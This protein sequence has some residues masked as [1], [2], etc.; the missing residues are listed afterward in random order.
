MAPISTT[1]P[2]PLDSP[3]AT[4]DDKSKSEKDSLGKFLCENGY[5]DNGSSGGGCYCR[6][7]SLD[8]A[9]VPEMV[10]D[11]FKLTSKIELSDPTIK[12]RLSDQKME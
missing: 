1:T 8:D 7:I 3:I 6:K 11:I 10:H 9:A 4:T 2:S 5:R 12:F